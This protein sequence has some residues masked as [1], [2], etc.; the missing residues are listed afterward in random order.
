[1]IG[2]GLYPA[3]VSEEPAPTPLQVGAF[4][5]G[6]VAYAEGRPS[7]DVPF[8]NADPDVGDLRTLWIRGWVLARIEHEYGDA[9]TRPTGR[10]LAAMGRWS[11]TRR[12]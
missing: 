9:D 3:S 11:T 6:A 1:M 10:Q 4:D 8:R 12:P 2:A 5:A 7:T